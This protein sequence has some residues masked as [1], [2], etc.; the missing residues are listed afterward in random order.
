MAALPA[1][2]Q[3]S[4]D[5]PDSVEALGTPYLVMIGLLFI[6]ALAGMWWYYMRWDDEKDDPGAPGR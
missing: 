3:Q 4:V 1:L 2:A 5:V 6:G